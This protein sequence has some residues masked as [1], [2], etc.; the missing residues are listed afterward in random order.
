MQRILDEDG[1]ARGRSTYSR[2][3]S[4]RTWWLVSMTVAIGSG[5]CEALLD[6]PFANLKQ[7]CAC[8]DAGRGR[9]D[10]CTAVG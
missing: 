6:S 10:C 7:R 9:D 1:R 3:T 5:M 2:D 8:P 4:N